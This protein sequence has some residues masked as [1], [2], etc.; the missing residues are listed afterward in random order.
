VPV[1]F[2]DDVGT[3]IDVQFRENGAPVDISA[4]IVKQILLRKPASGTVTKAA[5]FKTDGTD[6][7]ARYV[8]VAGD[9]NEAGEW[10][11]EGFVQLPTGEWYTTTGAFTLRNHL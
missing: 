4:A 8:T 11:V 5:T 1:G 9:Q 10:L 7:Y 2:V 3:Q 6:G